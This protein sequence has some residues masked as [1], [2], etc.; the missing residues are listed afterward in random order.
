MP[1]P[2]RIYPP[3]VAKSIHK[4]GKKTQRSKAV[5]IVEPGY[6]SL[7]SYLDR[8]MKMLPA[9]ALSLY[10]VGA[11]IIPADAPRGVSLGWFIFCLGAVIALRIW[12]TSD[13]DDNLPVDWVHVFISAVAFIIWVYSMGGPFKAYGIY[14]DYLGALLVLAWSF[15]VPM[16]YK[17][18]KI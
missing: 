7:G 9:E 17:G 11:G 10:L 4:H 13:K 6:D 8:L 16:I 1:A 18:Q 5:V 2:Y 14:I 12:G 15:F 3:G